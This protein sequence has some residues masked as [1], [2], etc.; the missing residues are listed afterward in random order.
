MSRGDF[1][2]AIHHFGDRLIQAI[3]R[4]GSPSCVGI[5]PVYE[6]L[7]IRLRRSCQAAVGRD[8]RQSGTDESRSDEPCP[9]SIALDA[10]CEYTLSVLDIVCDHIPAVKFQSACFERYRSEG[11]ELL[12]DMIQEAQSRGLIV[13]LDAKRGDIGISA[14]RYAEGLFDPIPASD[15]EPVVPE[16][17]SVPDA[18]T[19]NGYLGVDGVEPFCRPGRGVFVLVRTSNPGSDA[20]Q[21]VCLESGLSVAEHVAWLLAPLAAQHVG[22]AGYSSVGAVVAATRPLV[23]AAVRRQLPRSLFL[24]PGFGAQGGTADD[25]LACFD[26][27]GSGALITAS[28]SVSCAY[29]SADNAADWIDSVANAARAF[30]DEVACVARKASTHRIR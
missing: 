6:R 11:V 9:T 16:A 15:E 4:T 5:D 25:C 19:V 24:V 27:H 13:I 12:Y 29:E 30:A 22:D 28:R 2:N 18:V 3:E 14:Q 21:D 8:L 26:Q 17:V 20:L 23:A 1:D 7:P 10:I